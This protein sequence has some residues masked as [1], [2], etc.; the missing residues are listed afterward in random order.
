M[1]FVLNSGL[2]LQLDASGLVVVPFNLPL[3]RIVRVESLFTVG[4]ASLRQ[5]DL[6]VCSKLLCQS[7]LVF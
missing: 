3:R 2:H 1:E 6:V 5:R 4:N 7:L